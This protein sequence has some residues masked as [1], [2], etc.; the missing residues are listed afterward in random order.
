MTKKDFNKRLR[1]AHVLAELFDTH[2]PYFRGARQLRNR[3]TGFL[4]PELPLPFRLETRYGFEMIITTED[5]DIDYNLLARG[6]YE[7]G[8]L[9]IIQSCLRRG[10]VFIDIGANIGL[11]SLVA[12]IAV[13]EEGVVYAIEPEPNNFRLLKQNVG[14]NGIQNIS[15][16]NIGIAASRSKLTIYRNHNANRGTASFNPN[17]PEASESAAVEV[18][19][20]DELVVQNALSEVR[21]LKIDVEGWEMEVLEGAVQLLCHPK[22]PIIT[23]EYNTAFPIHKEIFEYISSVNNYQVFVLPHANWHT[24]QLVPVREQSDLPS[25]G[26]PNLF[27]FLPY[28]L[29]TVDEAV[30]KR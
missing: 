11:M 1:V 19:P 24:S 6:T 13:G 2:L 27:C 30:F 28:H 17:S 15:L 8:T 12:S 14:I 21:M 3:I 25:S 5:D 23:I 16:H 4:T 7:A 29:D 26:S 20:L 10:D 18:I 22:A 9:N